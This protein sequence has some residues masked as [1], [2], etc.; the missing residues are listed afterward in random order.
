[1]KI[2]LKCVIIQALNL[3]I[4]VELIVIIIIIIIT[5]L[6]GMLSMQLKWKSMRVFCQ[7]MVQC[8]FLLV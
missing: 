6:N 5:T 8:M 1:M 4:I 2:P 3:L 7:F